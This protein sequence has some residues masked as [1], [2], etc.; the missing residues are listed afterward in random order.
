MKMIKV[1]NL[2]FFVLP[3]LVLFIYACDSRSPVQTI[4]KISIK[5]FSVSECGGFESAAKRTVNDIPFARDASTYCNAERLQWLYDE[6]TQTLKVMNSRVLLNCCGEHE[7][8]AI[9]DNNIIVIKENDQPVNG[10]D[11]CRCMCVFDFF[12]EI[13][14]VK[15]DI[16]TLK[17]ELSVDDTTLNKWEGKVDLGQENGVIIIDDKPLE[18]GC[19]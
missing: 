15:P 7:I 4:D 18:Y 12:I 3:L 8:T 17:L 13:C 9:N 1:G 14:G 2:R 16:I 6:N 10:E 11:R 19:P 5:D